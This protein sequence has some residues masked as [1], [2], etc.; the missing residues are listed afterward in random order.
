MDKI[1]KYLE[2]LVSY[3]IEEPESYKLAVKNALKTPK[4]RKQIYKYRMLR[5]LSTTCTLMVI[6][7]GTVF[8]GYVVYEK[9]WKEPEQYTYEELQKNISNFEVLDDRKQELITEDKAKEIAYGI[10]EKLGYEERDIVLIELKNDYNNVQGEYYSMKTDVA[11][12]KGYDINIDARTGELNSFKNKELLFENTLAID[13]ISDELA[14]SYADKVFKGLNFSQ[15]QY[16][17]FDCNEIDYII[18]G[19][20]INLWEAKYN[21]KYNDVVNPYETLNVDFFVSDGNL[22]IR[23]VNKI[24]DGV[25]DQNS[26]IVNENEAIQIAKDKEAEITSNEI[27]DVSLELG[28]RKSNEYIYQLENN[29][30]IE[31]KEV[32]KDNNAYYMKNDS[33]RNVWIV[34]IRHPE[35]TAYNYKMVNKEYYIDTTTGEILGGKE[36]L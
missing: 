25:Y 6:V 31:N 10:I 36:M 27:V 9:I 3:E 29:I 1:D 35:N 12:D 26:I 19:K 2:K 32:T 15:E 34:K 14:K 17:Y 16:D 33:I 30:N 13:K 11:E 22:E 20:V 4:A 5:I 21:K 28:I 23:A 18:S 8:A 7:G 24:S